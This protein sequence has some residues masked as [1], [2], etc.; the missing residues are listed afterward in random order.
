MSDDEITTLESV[1]I[2]GKAYL[3]EENETNIYDGHGNLVAANKIYEE[4]GNLVGHYNFKNKKW[5]S[6]PSQPPTQML[7]SPPSWGI[8]FQ[9]HVGRPTWGYTVP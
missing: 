2:D 9:Q 1:V 5:I 8:L 7:P 4:H 6:G 3:R